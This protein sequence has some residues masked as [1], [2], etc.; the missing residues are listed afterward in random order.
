MGNTKEKGSCEGGG[1]R[2]G[3][4]EAW[5]S[6]CYLSLEGEEDGQAFPV[7]GAAY[8]QLEGGQ[9]VG[10]WRKAVGQVL[11]EQV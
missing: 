5:Q 10:A 1:G 2:Q 7:G 8:R 4:R 11:E 9:S 6:S 3:V